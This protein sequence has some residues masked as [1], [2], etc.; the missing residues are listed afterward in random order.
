[1]P[2]ALNVPNEL[3]DLQ[4]AS[5]AARE[6]LAG[7]EGDEWGTQWRSWREAAERVHAAITDHAVA[8][9]LSR[10]EVEVAVKK[11]VRHPE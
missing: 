10:Y 6:G 11:A 4:R 7:L 8:G 3:F 9:G 5:D 1:M 2:D